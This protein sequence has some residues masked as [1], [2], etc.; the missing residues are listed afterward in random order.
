LASGLSLAAPW[1]VGVEH[2]FF[3]NTAP[4]ELQH[5]VYNAMS[6]FIVEGF[7]TEVPWPYESCVHGMARYVDPPFPSDA[8]CRLHT[9]V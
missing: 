3:Y 6:D 4:G 8:T 5:T 1:Q 9:P 2:V 7:V